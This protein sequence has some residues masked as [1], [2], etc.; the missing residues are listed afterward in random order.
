MAPASSSSSDPSASNAEQTSSATNPTPHL[1]STTCR[2]PRKK[3]DW[4]LHHL[5]PTRLIKSSATKNPSSPSSPR[6]PRG[7]L[8]F[9]DRIL[10]SK[11]PRSHSLN[12]L[13][14]D[15][16]Q[17]LRTAS[18]G[19][20]GARDFK[21]NPGHCWCL[22]DSETIRRRKS[23]SDFF[24]RSIG[25][26]RHTIASERQRMIR[27]ADEECPRIPDT[28]RN[29]F[30]TPYE[31]MTKEILQDRIRM[32]AATMSRNSHSS[33]STEIP[34]ELIFGKNETDLEDFWASVKMGDVIMQ[35]VIASFN[36]RQYH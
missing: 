8:P 29:E 19:R 35:K 17:H 36:Y 30:L 18:L 10:A 16:V 13:V 25:K 4:I 20:T 24:G 6:T 9:L 33:H 34:C 2:S 5:S 21:P 28:I 15:D 14:D 11:R 31:R 23:L 12:E 26:R 7:R 32:V 3:R 1:G 27:F 22:I